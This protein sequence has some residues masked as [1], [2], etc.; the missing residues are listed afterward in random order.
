MEESALSKRV[1]KWNERIKPILKKQEMQN[2]FQLKKYSSKFIDCFEETHKYVPFRKIVKKTGS[3]E[4][5]EVSRQFLTMLQM[6]S[7]SISL[8]T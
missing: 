7:D 3:L 8:K 5:F 4:P 6:V 2:E 1:Y